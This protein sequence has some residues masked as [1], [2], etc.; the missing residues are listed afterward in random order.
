MTPKYC[1]NFI[2]L[3][4]SIIVKDLFKLLRDMGRYNGSNSSEIWTV[5]KKKKVGIV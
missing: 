5:R 3:S 4:K 1:L 2:V